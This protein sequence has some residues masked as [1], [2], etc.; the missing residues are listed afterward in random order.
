MAAPIWFTR[1]AQQGRRAGFSQADVARGQPEAMAWYR[2][3]ASQVA[4][5][6]VGRMLTETP[7]RTFARGG[8]EDV[9]SM[10]MFVYDPKHKAKLPYYDRVPLVFPMSFDGDSFLSVNLHYLPPVLRWQLFNQL[11]TLAVR[12]NDKMKRLALS[13]QI[14]N[15]SVRFA[16][17]RPCIKRHL[18]SHVRSRFMLI[19]PTEWP[20]A[21]A[22][23]TARFI[24]ASNERVWRD[25]RRIIRNA[26]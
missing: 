18:F 7:S 15:G 24:G 1:I 22:L 8:P 11:T 20:M 2:E 17:F 6:D 14:L 25:S 5:V 21:V 9:G 19:R 10:L 16:A 3:R 23:P 4:R 13:Y 26:R 12:E